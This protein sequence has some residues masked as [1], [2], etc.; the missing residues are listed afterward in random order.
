MRVGRGVY[1]R[2]KYVSWGSEARGPNGTFLTELIGGPVIIKNK[3]LGIA[4][5][6]HERLPRWPLLPLAS[7]SGRRRVAHVARRPPSKS[8]NP[9]IQCARRWRRVSIA[10]R[11]EPEGGKH[12]VALVAVRRVRPSA[13]RLLART[14]ARLRRDAVLRTGAHFSAR[15][16]RG[17]SGPPFGGARRRT[18]RQSCPA[19]VARLP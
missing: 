7:R 8:F 17:G 16:A 18:A 2:G 15:S 1:W 10:H 12:M 9:T 14:R 6:V 5:A 19:C 11:L 3:S 13:C 4:K